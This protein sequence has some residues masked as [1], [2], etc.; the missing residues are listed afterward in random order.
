M[1]I[2]TSISILL[3]AIMTVSCAHNKTRDNEIFISPFNREDPTIAAFLDSSVG[4]AIYPSVGKAAVGVGGAHG[5]GDVYEKGLL[6]YTLI[7]RSELS[8][9]SAGLQL[10]AQTYSEVIFFEN[11]DALLRFKRGETHLTANASAVFL[12]EGKKL[13]VAFHDGVAV[14]IRKKDGAMAELSVGGQKLSFK[15]L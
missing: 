3:T 5:K 12:E 6:G 14:V 2:L 13:D 10:G 15:P 8:Q 11:E 9:V 1:K 7:G 4:Y